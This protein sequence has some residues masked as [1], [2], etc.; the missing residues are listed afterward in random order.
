MTSVQT[1]QT[2]TR[3]HNQVTTESMSRQQ[4]TSDTDPAM[5]T[6]SV[7]LTSIDAFPSVKALRVMQ[8]SV[9]IMILPMTILAKREIMHEPHLVD[10]SKSWLFSHVGQV[11]AHTE[12][13]NIWRD[14]VINVIC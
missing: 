2:I 14:R 13:D 6:S 7:L 8:G 3:D 5:A 4:W 11:P 9:I 10:L 12:D 1:D